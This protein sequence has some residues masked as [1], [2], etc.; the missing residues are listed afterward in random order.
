[1][2][3]TERPLVV[4]QWKIQLCGVWFDAHGNRHFFSWKFANSPGDHYTWT[5]LMVKVLDVAMYRTGPAQPGPT[6]HRQDH[7]DVLTLIVCCATWRRRWIKTIDD[8]EGSGIQSQTSH[9]RTQSDPFPYCT[10]AFEERAL[11]TCE[12]SFIGQSLKEN[13]SQRSRVYI[14]R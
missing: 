7:H 13:V 12:N 4:T 10:A 5:L 1:M 14:Y 6:R 3:H 11:L 9:V 8:V 2:T